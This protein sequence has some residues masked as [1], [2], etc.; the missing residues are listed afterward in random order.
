MH[1]L[2]QNVSALLRFQY[3]MWLQGLHMPIRALS[4][5]HPG[6]REQIVE[7]KTKPPAQ[8][9]SQSSWTWNLD[10]TPILYHIMCHNG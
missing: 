5:K 1:V 4:V 3:V 6:L 2:F 10:P 8:N 9:A 7:E